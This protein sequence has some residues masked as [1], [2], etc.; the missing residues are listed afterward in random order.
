[1]SV[2]LQIQVF[3]LHINEL[4]ISLLIIR[5]IF[6]RAKECFVQ[7]NK[8]FFFGYKAYEIPFTLQEK[9][10]KLK[11]LKKGDKFPTSDLI[12]DYIKNK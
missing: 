12:I 1:V 11:H 4:Y 6:F 9:K 2:Q 3:H 10:P 7:E 8:M 5:E